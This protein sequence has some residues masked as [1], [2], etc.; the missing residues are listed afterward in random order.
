MN[1]PSIPADPTGIFARGPSWW[2][3][4]FGKVEIKPCNHFIMVGQ[5]GTPCQVPPWA[6]ST[7]YFSWGYLNHGRPRLTNHD[8]KEVWDLFEFPRLEDHP[9]TCKYLATMVIVSPLTGAAFSFQ[10]DI[11]GL[12]IGVT[13]L[14]TG[15]ILQATKW[16]NIS[17]NL[18]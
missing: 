1:T 9:M 4:L 15:M 8:F 5:P 14:L 3:A 12:Q 13:N 17:G 6:L 11:H 16:F 10:M 7:L 2:V 18:Y